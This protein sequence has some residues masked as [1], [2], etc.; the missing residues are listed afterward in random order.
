MFIGFD[1]QEFPWGEGCKKSA[2]RKAEHACTD[3]KDGL[4]ARSVCGADGSSDG[5][6]CATQRGGF[7]VIDTLGNFDDLG[8]GQEGAVGRETTV[9]GRGVGHLLMPVLVT[10]LAFLRQVV[11]AEEALAAVGNDG[12]DDSVVEVQRL[13]CDIVSRCIGAELDDLADDLVSED[14]WRMSV[15]ASADGVQIATTDRAS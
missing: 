12:P 13:A 15:T 8:A 4:I 1:A 6:R 5:C 3:D 7:K 9:P 11:L 10:R 14:C 2:G